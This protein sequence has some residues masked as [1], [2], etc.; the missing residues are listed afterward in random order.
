MIEKFTSLIVASLIFFQTTSQ[1]KH[2]LSFLI[3]LIFLTI[4][5]NMI[6]TWNI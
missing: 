6:E 3:L 5:N 1:Q 4:R 2:P